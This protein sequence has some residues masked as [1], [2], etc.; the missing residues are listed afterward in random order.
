MIMK[1]VYND[2]DKKMVK[3]EEEG[4]EIN[5]GRGKKKSNDN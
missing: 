3:K 2:E 1:M 5:D 4:K